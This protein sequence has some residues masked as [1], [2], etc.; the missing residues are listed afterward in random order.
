MSRQSC[1]LSC[2]LLICL[3]RM[4]AFADDPSSPI[5][6]LEDR[7]YAISLKGKGTKVERTSGDSVFLARKLTDQFGKP[8]LWSTNNE[9]DRFRLQLKDVPFFDT[10]GRFAIFLNGTC[11]MVG[12]YTDPKDVTAERSFDLIIDLYGRK[13]AD[14]VATRLG[15]KPRLRSHPGHRLL[16]SFQTT[17]SEY[18]LGQ[19]VELKLVITNQGDDPV[20]FMEGGKQRGARDNQFSFISSP[21]VPDTGDPMNFGG[22]G[23]FRTLKP[24][25]VFEKKIDITK[26]F[27][28]PKPGRYEI[29]GLYELELNTSEF[30]A[31]GLWDEFAVGRCSVTIVE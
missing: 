4:A 6:H 15:L 27:K 29:T 21:A 24:G 25:E 26:W 16:T 13:H 31:Q 14:R 20:Y 28:F 7:I 30:T 23:A 18:K 3:C 11:E 2:T 1:V 19:P 22:I 9:N 17:R 5:G 10:S 12:A 8:Q